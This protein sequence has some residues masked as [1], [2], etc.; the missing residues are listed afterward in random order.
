MQEVYVNGEPCRN[1]N[2]GN[3]N[4]K[5]FCPIFAPEGNITFIIL[6]YKQIYLCLQGDTRLY[7]SRLFV[8]QIF[9]KRQSRTKA[10]NPPVQKTYRKVSDPDK[11]S[12]KGKLRK[13]CM[14]ALQE[15]KEY[16]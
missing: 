10:V 5:Q 9:L 12:P 1:L 2:L 14:K 7:L 4:L 13:K 16:A 8:I 3:P 6:D 15:F 11:L